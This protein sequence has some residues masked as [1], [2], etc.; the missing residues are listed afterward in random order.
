MLGVFSDDNG[1]YRSAGACVCAVLADKEA[2]QA[3]HDIRFPQYED[4]G[5]H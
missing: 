4:T 5:A 2:K 3:C 1:A